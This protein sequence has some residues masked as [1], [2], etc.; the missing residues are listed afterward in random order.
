MRRA[1]RVGPNA[2]H[3][4]SVHNRRTGPVGPDRMRADAMCRPAGDALRASSLG[5]DSRYAFQSCY[6]SLGQKKAFS[7][8]N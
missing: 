6:W 2:L 3:R 8:H 1:G 5:P 4:W 7:H